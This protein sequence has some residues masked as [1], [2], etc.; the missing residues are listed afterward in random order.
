MEL[1]ELKNGQENK[2]MKFI[3]EKNPIYISLG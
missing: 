3:V 1:K 2:K